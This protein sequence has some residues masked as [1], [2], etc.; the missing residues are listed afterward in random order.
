MFAIRSCFSWRKIERENINNWDFEKERNKL[1]I[2]TFVF[3]ASDQKRGPNNK[4]DVFPKNPPS[5]INTT[6]PSKTK[7]PSASSTDTP[8]HP[9]HSALK[10]I[11]PIST[12]SNS[13]PRNSSQ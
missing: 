5:N 2:Y 1:A 6:S 12:H 4:T 10:N 11:S 7:M 8:L 9:S 13:P 3:P